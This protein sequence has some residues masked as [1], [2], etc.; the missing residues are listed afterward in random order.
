MKL[1]YI[2]HDDCKPRWAN[3]EQTL[4]DLEV[5]FPHL[6]KLVPYT[7][8]QEDPGWEHS[9]EIFWRAAGG[10]FGPV[11]DYVPK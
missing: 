8:A 9:E 5:Y 4:I 2:I 7:A 11:A 3:Q 10:E 1:D 6:D